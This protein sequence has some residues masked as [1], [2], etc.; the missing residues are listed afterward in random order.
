M[1][2]PKRLNGTLFKK[3]V[4]NAQK[5]LGEEYSAKLWTRI[6]GIYYPAKEIILSRNFSN[7]KRGEE[8]VNAF[9][10]AASCIWKEDYQT[11]HRTFGLLEKDEF[12]AFL[13]FCSVLKKQSNANWKKLE[14]VDLP[15]EKPKKEFKTHPIPVYVE[16]PELQMHLF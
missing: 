9:Q 4:E 5:D 16:K 15:P 13:S 1:G 6:K 11:L 2:K 14:V 3:V 8:M 7:K 12:S 10:N